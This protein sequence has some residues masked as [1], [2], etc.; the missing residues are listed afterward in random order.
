MLNDKQDK[1]LAKW[2]QAPAKHLPHGTDQE[3]RDQLVPMKITKWRQEGN[4]LIGESD[5]GRVV[6]PIPTNMM[7]K[8]TDDKG[9]PI[10][11]KLDI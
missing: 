1:D 3:I 8:G 11:V 6:N 9:M 5:V 2:G 10:L 7:L 4:K